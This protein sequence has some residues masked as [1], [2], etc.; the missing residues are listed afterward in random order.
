MKFN[1]MPLPH[2][3]HYHYRMWRWWWCVRERWKC[4]TTSTA[5]PYHHRDGRL[6]L[7]NE[8]DSQVPEYRVSS[9]LEEYILCSRGDTMM[10]M[11]IGF[12]FFFWKREKKLIDE[13]RYRGTDS[14]VKAPKNK[15]KKNIGERGT[16]VYWT[17]ETTYVVLLL[18][19]SFGRGLFVSL[20]P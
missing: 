12:F 10:M 17:C 13:K 18:R 16:Y 7:I 14:K 11:S 8:S 5:C 6:L 4:F 3:R 20:L 2:H 9:K 15:N 19:G 1:K